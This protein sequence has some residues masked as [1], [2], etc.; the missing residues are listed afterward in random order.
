MVAP[1]RAVSMDQIEV[2]DIWTNCGC[3]DSTVWMHHMD[4]DKA[5]WEQA[6]RELHEKATS[7][8]KQIQEETSN[9]KAVVR[10]PTSY[11]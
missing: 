7:N 9:E 1:E 11:L 4:A 5:Y 8:T 2:F 3:V 10:P 6:R